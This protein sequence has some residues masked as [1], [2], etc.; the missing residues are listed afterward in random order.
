[1]ADREYNI[2]VTTEA[3]TSEVDDL[4]SKLEELS[5]IANNV[6]SDVSSSLEEIGD[7]AEDTSSSL[8][9]ATESSDEL[10]D[11]LGS[12]DSGGMDDA[13]E[14]ADDLSGSLNDADESARGLSDSLGL[15]EGTMMMDLS[16]QFGSAGTEAEGMAQDMNTAAI[17]VG[18]LATQ[19]G[20]AEPQMVSLI[21][22]IS[23]ATFP[24]EEAMAY[25]QALNQ[26]GV[27]SEN[28]GTSATNMDRIN[29]AFH[30]GYQNTIKLTQ[31]LRATGVD[32]NHL[33]TSFNALAYTQSNVTGGVG[34]LTTVLQRNGAILNEYG[35][36]I[37][38]TAIIMGKLSERGLSARQINSQLSQSLKDCN[39]DVRALEQSLGLESGTLDNAS[40]ITGQ[41]EGQLQSL[42][43]EEMQ[44][45]TI[46][47]QLG[48]AYED[49]TLSLSPVLSPL[50]SVMGM[51]GQVGQ[52]VLGINS[53]I[54]LTQT[55]K[56]WE[57]VT[58][59]TTKAQA[60]LNFVMSLNPIILVVI[61]IA[62]LIAILIYLYYTN[63][64]V[65][66]AIDGLGQT[67]MAVGQMIYTGFVNVINWIIGA[68]QNLWNYI[69]T[70]GGLLPANVE[71]TGNNI[72]DTIIRVV[73]FIT[74][75]PLQIQ[76]IFINI[77]AQALGFG[78]NFSQR[79]IMGAVNS[80]NGFIRYISQLP[81]KLAGELNKMLQMAK[82][83]VIQ[84]ANLLTGGAAGMVIG[85]ITGSGEHSP[86][87][88]YDAFEGE[89]DA[90]V[91]IVPK[92]SSDLS[93]NVG[94][95]GS[96]MVDEFGN[97]RFTNI[98]FGGAI[99]NNDNGG[100]Y[101]PTINI[102]VGSVDNQKRIDEI[103]NAVTR[104]L[105]WNNTTAG[106]TV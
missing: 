56:E 16:N 39:G 67:F 44:H 66:N 1:M 106:R 30:I 20:M 64:D 104:A 42:A 79:M 29:D 25:V 68:L 11:S 62:A 22:Y 65:R 2:K 91:N 47:D 94:L 61:A 99:K 10:S 7:A 15:I 102:E 32:V 92:Y 43:D 69:I 46:V 78:D 82:D 63:E 50:T 103:V 26:M 8:D 49:L 74:T 14:S 77:I 33:D 86:G 97:T 37:D 21:N 95:L 5:D 87:Y 59:L 54:T 55:I 52:W 89:L 18:Q 81:G 6:S 98:E 28:F 53:I 38:Q 4:K 84:I 96:D 90:M 23:N 60:A 71:I 57:A 93:R 17:T 70:L 48:A 31:G 88:M 83:F 58:W 72:I 51:V 9:N 85:W 105:R 41:Y 40:A 34:T 24:N 76:M 101:S 73:M 35:L 36:S 27:A 80:V 13:R 75:L 3:D 12:M 100:V 19:T 45:K